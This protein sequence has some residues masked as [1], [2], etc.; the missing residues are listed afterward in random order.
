MNAMAALLL[1]LSV[2][3]TSAFTHNKIN[4]LRTCFTGGSSVR[5]VVLFGAGAQLGKSVMDDHE[6]L[7]AEVEP[8]E[9]RSVF[10]RIP[11]GVGADERK[12]I[13]HTRDYDSYLEIK[14][15]ALSIIDKNRR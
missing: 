3:C 5:S 10:K 13:L 8:A 1:I 11:V 12:K 9:A 2:L 7:V 6:T 15:Q 4:S 14:S